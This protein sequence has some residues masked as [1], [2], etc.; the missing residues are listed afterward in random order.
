MSFQFDELYEYVEQLFRDATDFEASVLSMC[1]W[2]EKRVPHEDWSRVKA[3]SAQQ[4]L[5]VARSWLYKLLEQ[6]SCPFSPQAVF[7]NVLDIFGEPD[8]Y[9]GYGPNHADVCPVFF[10]T[11]E[12]DDAAMSWIYGDE[13]YDI[14]DSNANLSTLKES[15]LI[16][17]SAKDS[18]GG[19]A[20]IAHSLGYVLLMLRQLL[21]RRLYE[22]LKADNP[23]GIAVGFDS[24]DLFFVGELSEEGFV[25]NSKPFLQA[26]EN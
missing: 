16:F 18:I 20:Y 15:G 12:P 3:L 11:C 24:G 14:E 6:S 25:V 19:D 2:L 17:N 23:V 22:L 4:D 21:D 1:E 7:F 26:A 9:G 13:R 5:Q 8:D 10:A